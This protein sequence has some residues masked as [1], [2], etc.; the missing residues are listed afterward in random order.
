MESYSE[1]VV[2]LIRL[3]VVGLVAGLFSSILANKDH[4]QRKWWELRVSA[5][6]NAIEALSDLV[7]YYEK[8]YNAEI[9]SREL[10]NEFKEKLDTYWEQAY[11]KIR[12]AADSGAFLFSDKANAALREFVDTDDHQ[13]YFEYLDD[14]LCK[15]QKCL[16]LL[17]EC[18][19][20]DL[21]LH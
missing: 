18:S 13:S 17:I 2:D 8:H 20:E 1:I 19:K 10:P 6:Q 15:A 14:N 9:E 5:Y 7:Y 4:R 3:G 21:K 12:K 16:K 11:P